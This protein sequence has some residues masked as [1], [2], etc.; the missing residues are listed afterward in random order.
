LT[1]TLDKYY[2]KPHIAQ[3]CIDTLMKYTEHC[4]D[5]IEP[6]A[7]SGVFLRDFT[8]H[9][10]DLLPECDTVE[11]ANWLT[12]DT[13]VFQDACVYGNPPYGKRNNLSKSFIRKSCEFS[14]VV[15]FVLPAV[16]NK[17]TLQSVFTQDWRLVDSV[18]LPYNSFTE[19]G[20]D[21]HIP[22]VF[23]VWSKDSNLPCYR[24]QKRLTFDNK[25]FS[26]VK[27]NCGDIYVM[28]ASPRT[29]KDPAEVSPHNRGYWI[30]C[31]ISKQVVKSNFESIKWV[32]HSSASGGVAWHT[33]SEIMNVYEENYNESSQQP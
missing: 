11:E 32:G 30:K 29:V 16:Y 15:A 22:S 24:V 27:E 4:K 31:H 19:Y 7:G 23:Q 17:H 14:K 20:Q 13:S 33:K 21:Y 9:A 28:G 18:T 12:K 3:I 2:T 8:T 5:F 25:H 10:Y 26:I 6:S 1:N